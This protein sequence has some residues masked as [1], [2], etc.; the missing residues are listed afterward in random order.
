MRA[1]NYCNARDADLICRGEFSDPSVFTVRNPRAPMAPLAPRQVSMSAYGVRESLYQANSDRMFKHGQVAVEW[2][3]PV[4][5]GGANITAY[6]LWMGRPGKKAFEKVPMETFG[7]GPRDEGGLGSVDV[8]P[9][10]FGV[11]RHVVGELDEGE[12]YRFYVQ[13]VNGLGRSAKSPV[14]SMI[15]ARK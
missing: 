3:A 7:A 8:L 14:T 10:R 9:G 13:A 15:A 4:D 5:N 2:R 6:Q 1:V 12:L 11:M